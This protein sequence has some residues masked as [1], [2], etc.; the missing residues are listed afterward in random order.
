MLVHTSPVVMRTH[1]HN[2]SLEKV[3]K[4]YKKRDFL[5]GP[6]TRCHRLCHLTPSPCIR[7][8]A[9]ALRMRAHLPVG[10]TGG[11]GCSAGAGGEADGPCHRGLCG[12]RV[13]GSRFVHRVPAYMPVPSGRTTRCP[14]S[15]PIEHPGDALAATT[16]G[17]YWHHSVN[18]KHFSTGSL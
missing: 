11:L 8:Q 14:N 2:D 10:A 16:W 13:G 7:V 17:K 4:K 6:I 9:P 5:Q 15:S 3:Q 12:S 18:V 1:N